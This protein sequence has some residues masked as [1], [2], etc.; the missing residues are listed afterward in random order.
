MN[1]R[2]HNGKKYI[3]YLSIV[4]FVFFSS[5]PSAAAVT[6]RNSIA[7]P[8]PSKDRLGPDTPSKIDTTRKINIQEN[9]GQLPLYFVENKGQVV[10]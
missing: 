7:G 2:K 1:S 3:V 8:L 4:I 6:K 9:Y 5:F 10:I